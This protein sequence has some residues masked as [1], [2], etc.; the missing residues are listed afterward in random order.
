MKQNMVCDIYSGICTS[1]DDNTIETIDFNFD[2]PKLTLYY[3]TDPMCSHCWAFE[4][5]LNK[6]LVQY[7][8]LFNFQMVMGGL[9][10][11]WGDG[12]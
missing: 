10:E 8:H 6:L 2:T 5:I 7:G 1:S 11:A 9:L 3:V 12:P 4:P